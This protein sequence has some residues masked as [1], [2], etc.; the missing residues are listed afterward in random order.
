M[1]GLL[2]PDHYRN[3]QHLLHEHDSLFKQSW[4]F[5]GLLLEHQ[6]GEHRGVRLGS[7]SLIIQCDKTGRPRAFLNVCSHRHAQLC[8][9]GLHRGP[10]RCPYHSWTYDKEGIPASI[11]QPQAFP[12]VVADKSAHRLKEFACETAGQFIFVRLAA[13]G[14][15][16]RDYL[17]AEYDFLLRASAGMSGLIDEFREDVEA[18]W[19]AVIE[20]SL[21]GYHVPAVHN[22]TFMKAEGMERGYQAPVNNL[23][24]PLHSHI[25]H[26]AEADWLA[27]FER[28]VAPK[29]GQWA[30]KFPHYTHHLIF[31]N[32]TVTSFL[33]YSF[34]IQRFEPTSA[35]VTTV[36]SRTVGVNFDQQTPVGARMIEQI[37]AE[38]RDF[39]SRVFAE[40]AQISRAV[41]RGLESAERLA[42]IGEGIEDRV[43]HFQ[44]AYQAWMRRPENTSPA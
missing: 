26:P 16:L 33:G 40:D 18:N 32:L 7:T 8:E 27:N 6:G 12:E 41:Q 13:D 21:E 42:V 36:H 11:P 9:P 23:A 30:W 44:R 25:E 5:V 37:Y 31:P 22:K 1:Q 34:H 4:N 28:R 10:I 38:S 39:T 3:Q 29:I 17:G 15:S 43:L 2:H 24:H 14:P 19:K 35:G 20:N